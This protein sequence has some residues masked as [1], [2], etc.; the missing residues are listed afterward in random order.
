MGLPL[1]LA[2]LEAAVVDACGVEN[3]WPAQIAAGIGAGL[4]YAIAHPEVA[5]SLII[6]AREG[7]HGLR[8]G[9]S[10]V[11]RLAGFLRSKAPHGDRLP[12]ATDEMIVAGMVN[13]VGDHL[14]AG[15]SDRL[16]ELRPD[17]VLL[18]LL[19]YLGFAEAQK[20][21]NQVA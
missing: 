10:M 8:P 7:V 18:A 20:W 5:D 21:A 2:N 1:V 17:L 15:R 19:P 11:G 3:E 9:R 13:V 14:R 16:E 6:G 4:E 12:G